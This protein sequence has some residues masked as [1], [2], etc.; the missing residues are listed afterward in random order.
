M[1]KLVANELLCYV[2]NNVTK[3]PR[4]LMGVALNGFYTDEEVSAAKVCL[5]SIL[6]E[7]KVEGLPRLIRRQAA[8]NR[9]KQECDDILSL[10]A[11]ADSAK[12]S[13]P[14]FVAANLQRLPSVNPGDVDVYA[15]AASVAALSSQLEV[16]VKR[17]DSVS[18]LN[19]SSQME[20]MTRR[21]DVCEAVLGR[22][23]AVVTSTGQ[24]AE[25]SGALTERSGCL[26]WAQ[27]VA[28]PLL[29]QPSKVAQTKA[30]IIRVKGS[31]SQTKVK[32]VPR[33]PPVKLL[34]AFVGRMDPETTE[35]DLRCF[36]TDAGLNVVHC[37]K[38]KPPGGRSFKTAAF[39]VTCTEDC[40]EQFYND[41]T[42]PDGAEL[43]DWY[44]TS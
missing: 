24:H 6:V 38:L 1:A 30:P 3:H 27:R 4:A 33:D 7:M 5:H 16:L 36:L 28:Q 26:S 9:R 29:S 18:T 22:G 15:L 12:C 11:F 43:R 39:Y 42:W 19:I 13:L 17:V 41:E 8:D 20:L 34:K 25:E 2:Q 14:T 35:E 23:E 40:E 31:S 10:F 37:R 21:L 32:A 44:T